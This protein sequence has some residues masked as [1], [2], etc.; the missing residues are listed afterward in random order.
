MTCPAP[1]V[2]RTIVARTMPRCRFWREMTYDTVSFEGTIVDILPDH[3]AILGGRP[4]PIQNRADFQRYPFDELPDLYWRCWEPHLEALA[5]VMPEGMKA[6]GGCGN[7]VFEISED[8]VGYEYLC[9]LMFDDPQTFADL[10]TTIGKLMVTLWS[11]MLERYGHLLAV[12]RMGD[13]LGY[14]TSTLLAPPTIVAHILPQ[15]RRIVGLVHVAQKPFLLHCCGNIFPVM[16]DILSTGIDAKHSNEDQIA[17]FG[18]W[19]DLY[20]GRIGLFGGIDL[21]LLC[22]QDRKTVFA[23]VVRQGTEFATRRAVSPLDR[24]IPSPTMCRWTITSPCWKPRTRCGAHVPIE[25]DVRLGERG[26]SDTPLLGQAP[27][28]QLDTLDF[29]QRLGRQ[30]ASPQCGQ[31]TIG[32]FSMTKRLAPF[33]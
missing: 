11:R 25:L 4:G 2:T 31:V 6:I 30:I 9:L 1:A 12:C 8:L 20:G 5:K 29:V 18:K 24:A 26:D 3:G 15:Y 13:D 17:P 32:T 10:Y 23:E 19:I 21:N 28:M 22:T 33:P 7:G 14:K 27:T 16:D